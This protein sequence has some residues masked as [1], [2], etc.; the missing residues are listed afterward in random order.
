MISLND[1]MKESN[2]YLHI[3]SI[4]DFYRISLFRQL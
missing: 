4:L 1:T 3:K 2:K